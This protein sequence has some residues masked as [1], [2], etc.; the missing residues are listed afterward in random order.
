VSRRTGEQFR[1]DEVNIF[2]AS[3]TFGRPDPVYEYVQLE[4]SV[5]ESPHRGVVMIPAARKRRRYR[6]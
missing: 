4:G 5:C 6:R 3:R 1:V 2:R